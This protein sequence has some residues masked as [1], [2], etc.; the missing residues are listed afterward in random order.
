MIDAT[1]QKILD[2]VHDYAR[3]NYIMILADECEVV[4]RRLFE[5]NSPKRV[6]EIGTAIG[7]SSSVMAL[8]S[9]CIIDTIEKDNERIKKAKKLWKALGIEERINSFEGDSKELLPQVV[10][11]KIYDFIFIDGAKSSYKNQL[12]FLYPYLEKG[13][14]VLCDDVLYLGL[15]RGQE[16]VIHKHRTIV[17]NMREFLDYIQNSNLFESTVFEEGNG[18]AV[19]RKK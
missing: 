17:K 15:V 4:L 8:M 2:K 13:G 7:Y 10:K 3:E 9:D 5:E 19:V 18:I 1:C 14:I 16:K 6:L 11:D 12:E